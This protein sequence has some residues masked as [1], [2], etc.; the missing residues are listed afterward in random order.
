MCNACTLFVFMHVLCRTWQY[1]TDMN[2]KELYQWNK[3]PCSSQGL[4]H[5]YI[6]EI[7]DITECFLERYVIITCISF[8]VS[9]QHKRPSVITI[10]Y[11]CRW[12]H[13]MADTGIE[14]PLNDWDNH[15]SLLVASVV[16]KM[17]IFI[18]ASDRNF[19]KM[20]FLYPRPTKLEGGILDSPCPSVC[21]SVRPSVC[22]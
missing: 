7:G 10:F 22:L 14:V 1:K 6:A 21:P 20:V 16:V 11:V 18:A 9:I 19:A 8:I 12:E 3:Y 13:W 4:K 5:P 17:I 2:V 15:I